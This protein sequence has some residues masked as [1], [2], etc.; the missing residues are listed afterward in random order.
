MPRL[1]LAP[2]ILLVPSAALAQ[3]REFTRT[4]ALQSGGELRLEIDAARL[5]AA[6]RIVSDRGQIEVRIP[7]SQPLRVRADLHRRGS[8]RSDFGIERS[9]RRETFVDATIN[10]GGPELTLTSDRTSFLLSRRD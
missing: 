2:A 9:G 3:S 10:V 1:L 7:S 4:I 5:D 8:F 6:S